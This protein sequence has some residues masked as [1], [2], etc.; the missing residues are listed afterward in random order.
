MM[1]LAGCLQSFIASAGGSGSLLFYG[2]EVTPQ[3]E[4]R[5]DFE[6][7][8][9]DCRACTYQFRLSHA[10]GDSPIWGDKLVFGEE[11]LSLQGSPGEKPTVLSLGGGHEEAHVL[12]QAYEEQPS[13]MVV[14]EPLN[15]CRVYHFHDTSLINSGDND[16]E[17]RIW[18][19][20]RPDASNLASFLYRLKH[21]SSS[22][23]YRRIVSTIGLVAPFFEDFHLEPTGPKNESIELN[24]RDKESGQVFGAHQLSDG[25]LCHVPHH[26]PPPAGEGTPRLGHR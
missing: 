5:L 4:A 21:R 25:T 18:P 16:P 19:G 6:M 14:R 13:A 11:K 1:S 7:T 10:P 9:D 26:A 17:S 3:M 23:A 24:W 15:G 20:L 22:V 2:P 8:G 12:E